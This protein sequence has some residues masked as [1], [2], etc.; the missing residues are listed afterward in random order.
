MN[1]RNPPARGGDSFVA[2]QS[3][4]EVDFQNLFAVDIVF[5]EALGIGM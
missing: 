1:G 4:A 3:L 5:G 2:R